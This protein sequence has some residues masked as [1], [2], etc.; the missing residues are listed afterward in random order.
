MED[1]AHFSAAVLISI[2][3]EMASAAQH[4]MLS[5][6]LLQVPPV[7]QREWPSILTLHRDRQV[8]VCHLSY[9]LFLVMPVMQT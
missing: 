7:S 5:L 2:L 1:L 9:N 6:Q 4:Q 8:N 3:E